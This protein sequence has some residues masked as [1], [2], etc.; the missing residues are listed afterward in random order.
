M[1]KIRIFCSFASPGSD[2][3]KPFIET[4]ELKDDPEYNTVYCF[5]NDDDYTHAILLNTPM[6]ELKIPK[7]NVIGLAFEPI[8]FLGLTPQFVDYAQKYIGKYFIGSKGDLPAPFME[9][10]AYMWHITPLKEVKQE[11]TNLMSI[12]ISNKLQAEGHKYRHVLANK[13]LESN[14]PI[15]IY[16]HGCKYYWKTSDN[17][18]KGEFKDQRLMLEDYKYHIC[19][20]NYESSHYFSKNIMDTLLYNTVPI[21]MGC[22]NIDTYFPQ[23]VI[24]LT[25]DVEKDWK[26]LKDICNYPDKY[27]RKINIDEVKHTISIKRLIEN[28]F[29]STNI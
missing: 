1:I 19:I 15:D 9:H 22:V 6:P 7:E 26:L 4:S 2:C 20:E 11:K 17:R 21:Y 5:T 23:N 8:Q 25:G 27:S 29:Y 3:S 10:F 13:I 16:G 14:L 24:H 12:M 18:L 28:N